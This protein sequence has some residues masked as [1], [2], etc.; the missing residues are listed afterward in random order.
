MALR[1]G[2]LREK[3]DTLR[4]EMLDLNDLFSFT[5]SGRR[6]VYR[7]FLSEKIK[8]EQQRNLDEFAEKNQDKYLFHDLMA[9]KR[10]NLKGYV[11][12]EA[13]KDIVA[14]FKTEQE[15]DDDL[16]P[17]RP[18]ESYWHRLSLSKNDDINVLKHNKDLLIYAP[19]IWNYCLD[20]RVTAIRSMDIFTIGKTPSNCRLTYHFTDVYNNRTYY[21]KRTDEKYILGLTLLEELLKE[22][23]SK[24]S[25]AFTEKGY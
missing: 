10:K 11:K 18:N 24:E 23:H 6:T 25:K 9:M 13:M 17:S 14:A 1:D 19:E 5:L 20:Y 21:S 15:T 22:A 7:F 16:N 12:H 8:E 2:R 4:R 3:F